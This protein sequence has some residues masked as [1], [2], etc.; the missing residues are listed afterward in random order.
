MTSVARNSAPGSAISS[1]WLPNNVCSPSRTPSGSPL[2]DVTIWNRSSFTWSRNAPGK[3]VGGTAWL[4]A[5]T[6]DQRLTLIAQRSR[7][8]HI[9]NSER[10]GD[11][12]DA[13]V[14]VIMRRDGAAQ[15]WIRIERAYPLAFYPATISLIWA[16]KR[17]G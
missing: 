2:M 9:Q 10:R 1:V 15:K 17:T 3:A 11:T 12:D 5:T 8:R 16:V 4:P 14:G 7:V 6:A 13:V